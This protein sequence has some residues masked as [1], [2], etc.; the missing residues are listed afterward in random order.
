MHMLVTL[1]DVAY[2]TKPDRAEYSRI[3]NRMKAAKPREVDKLEFCKHIA[4]GKSFIGGAFDRGLKHLISWQIAALDFDDGK[5]SP[6]E[7]LDR[8]EQLDIAPM[9][10]YF[11]LSSTVKKPRFRLVFDLGQSVHDADVAADVIATLMHEFPESDAQ[12]RN[13]N[14]IFLGSNGEVWQCW[15]VWCV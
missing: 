3:T 11:T 8:C 9:L 1:D 12:C 7:A 14:R 6:I 4:E 10:L 15:Q 5:I 2:T 13:A